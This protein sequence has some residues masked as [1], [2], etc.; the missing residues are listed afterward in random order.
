MLSRRFHLRAVDRKNRPVPV[1]MSMEVKGTVHITVG[2]GADQTDLYL[3]ASE[4]GEA[5]VELATGRKSV[6]GKH[7]MK[8]AEETAHE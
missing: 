1:Y 2:S 8:Q 3:R 4:L 5:L 7:A 6:T